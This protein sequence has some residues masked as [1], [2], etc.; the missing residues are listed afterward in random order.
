MVY[1]CNLFR[2]I[3]PQFSFV[4]PHK[5]ILWPNKL[6]FFFVELNEFRP[7]L[8]VF[9]MTKVKM[10]ALRCLKSAQLIHFVG[11]ISLKCLSH[12]FRAHFLGLSYLI[13]EL[14]LVAKLALGHL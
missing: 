13:L 1:L 3:L 4:S 8:T 5:V 14:D 2:C 7:L 9:F 12:P 11:I 10:F 6:E